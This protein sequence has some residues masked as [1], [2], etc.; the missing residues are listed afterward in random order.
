[1]APSRGGP[2]IARARRRPP[3]PG[4]GRTRLLDR[5][6]PDLV[7]RADRRV[8]RVRPADLDAQRDARTGVLREARE[9]DLAVRAVDGHRLSGERLRPGPQ[10]QPPPRAADAEGHPAHHRG[11]PPV[12]PAQL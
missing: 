2:A 3:G 12:E 7:L 11:P 6:V 10:P 1:M 9:P 4:R 8:L 5:R